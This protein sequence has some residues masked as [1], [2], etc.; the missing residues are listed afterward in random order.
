MTLDETVRLNN[1]LCDRL[2]ELADELDL[3]KSF[4][5]LKKRP[6]VIDVARR[7][8]S[9]S[10]EGLAEV[11]KRIQKLEHA[12]IFRET[13][14]STPAILDPRWCG[15]NLNQRNKEIFALEC[16]NLL[17]FLAVA[18]QEYFHLGLSN[19]QSQHYLNQ[20]LALNLPLMSSADT[21]ADRALGARLSKTRRNL[22]HFLLKQWGAENLLRQLVE[23]SKRILAQR[24]I[25]VDNVKSMI[26]EIS[27]ALYTK[28]LELNPD[29]VGQAQILIKALYGPT[30]ASMGDPG[31]EEYQRRIE[32]MNQAELKTECE[33]FAHSMYGT[34]LVSPYHVWFI[35]H[36]KYEDIDLLGTAMGLSTTGADS[37]L[38]YRSLVEKL[39]DEAIFPETAQ[40]LYGLSLI[41]ERGILY[42]PAVG[43]S[44]WSHLQIQLSPE[45]EQLL[46]TVFGEAHP[47][48]VILLAGILNI[49][50]QPFGVGQGNN[51]TCQSARAISMWAYNDPDYLLKLLSRAARDN[52]VIMHFEGHRISSKKLSKGLA[53]LPPSDLEPVSLVLTPHLD[54][55]YMEM[56][57]HCH[58]RPEDPHK[59]IN[60]EFHGWWVGRGFEIAVDIKTGL[61]QNYGEF[62]Q[63]FYQSYH[64]YYN[65]NR[66]V[67]HPQPAGIA[68]TDSFARFVGWHAITIVRVALDPQGVMRTYFFNPNNDSGQDWGQG[69]KVSTE[70]HG[71]RYGES[72]LPIEQLASRLYIFHYDPLEKSREQLPENEVIHPIIELAHQSW[73]NDRQVQ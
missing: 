35:R 17:R 53:S 13:D 46:K 12:G 69:I 33:H 28:S 7:L 73:A 61:L 52:E 27:I 4:A 60:P 18:K 58:G 57:R 6:R 29:D 10:S 20:F 31:F 63:S 56:G 5:K 62:L 24:P 38:C 65:N 64:P 48:R 16:L 50:G 34:G 70:N 1:K 66:P 39:I 45:T 32:K 71:E 55:V 14:Y 19:E 68:V 36:L 49:L 15:H 41:L 72:S 30:P 54:K 22:Y 11:Y 67:I 47:P 42:I 8:M 59:W 40:A 25:Q 44:L 37:L 9:G 23:E 43:P 51:P 21:E 3:A 2:D 26:T